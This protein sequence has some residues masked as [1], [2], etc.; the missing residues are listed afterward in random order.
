M[1][2]R[3][4]RRSAWRWVAAL[5]LLLPLLLVRQGA[6]SVLSGPD[7]TASGDPSRAL[8]LGALHV[9]SVA[10]DGR[11]T[12]EEIA[13][14]AKAAGLS[15]VVMSDHNLTPVPAP[16]R[17]DGVLMA[18]A[19][20]ISTTDGHLLAL[21][22]QGT[23][24]PYPR[25]GAE[26]VAWAEEEGAFLAL[27]HPVQKKNPWKDPESSARA[28][29]FELYSADTLFR[30]ALARPFSRLLPAAFGW[31]GGRQHGVLGLVHDQPRVRE[32]MLS[33][34]GRPVALCSHDAHGTPPYRDVFSTMAT[35]VPVSVLEGT[36]DEATAR[37]FE[38]IGSGDSLCVF[39]ALGRPEGFAIEGG[40]GAREVAV[41]TTLSLTLPEPAQ[42]RAEV[43][44]FGPGRLSEDGRTVIATG[45][46]LL[47]LE[48]WTPA[49][50]RLFGTQ[51]KPWL[52]PSPF[53][54]VP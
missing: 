11:G 43:R 18:Y 48:V 27:A 10:S 1:R 24:P 26:A 28:Q 14:A 50:G 46:G 30:D 9:H 47:Q 2:D 21:G 45:P 7:V 36:A 13:A 41:G 42:A 15:F 54:V 31:L 23:L 22:T 53:R 6:C 16:H 49:P 40:N 3:G 25:T 35:A 34:D 5:I 39:Q 20:E 32:A 12:I 19:V 4:R 33:R 44:V 52:V 51:M 29:G 37:L 38:M 8:A 17:I